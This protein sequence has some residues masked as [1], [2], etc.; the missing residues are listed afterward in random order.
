[1]N[2][3]ISRNEKEIPVFVPAGPVFIIAAKCFSAIHRQMVKS[4]SKEMVQ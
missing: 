1:M 3:L 4:Q 2:Y